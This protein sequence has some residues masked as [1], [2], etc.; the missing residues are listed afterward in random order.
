MG[1]LKNI[2]LTYVLEISSQTDK[3]M[4]TN[5]IYLSGI[6]VGCYPAQILWG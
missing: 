4:R 3:E 5:S 1:I 2:L 6:I